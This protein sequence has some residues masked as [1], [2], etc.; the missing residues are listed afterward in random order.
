MDALIFISALNIEIENFI[1]E[2][3]TILALEISSQIHF[4]H[5]YWDYRHF[6]LLGL[7]DSLI[8]T[9]PFTQE[10]ECA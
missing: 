5:I 9:I 3:Y 6:L 4:S 1:R 2:F 7:S 8:A 10:G